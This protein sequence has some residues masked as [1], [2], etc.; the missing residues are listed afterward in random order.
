MQKLSAN[1]FE[2]VIRNTPL[3]SIDL[4]IKN[5][6]HKILLGWRTNA[7]AKDTWFVPGGRISKNETLPHAFKRISE[8][9]TGVQVPVEKSEFLGI[10]EHIY[11]GDNVTK[12]PDFGTHYIVL[13]FTLQL[14]INMNNLPKQQHTKYTWLTREDILTNDRVHQNTKNYFNG[15][16]PFNQLATNKI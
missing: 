12:N 9:E 8:A 13:A 6:E 16:L 3:I 1:E 10:Y 15:Y 14:D 5:S 11:P 4:I 7:P 2:N